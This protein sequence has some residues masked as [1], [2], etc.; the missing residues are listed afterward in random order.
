[1]T[2]SATDHESPIFVGV[3]PG[4]AFTVTCVPQLGLN[5]GTDEEEDV[6]TLNCLVMA[7]WQVSRREYAAQTSW[8]IVGEEV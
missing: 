4:T 7:P 6:L 5:V 2:I 8:S 3:F 1:M